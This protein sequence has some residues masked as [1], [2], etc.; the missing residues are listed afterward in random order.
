M[1]Y[2]RPRAKKKESTWVFKSD[3]SSKK[4][5]KG[6]FAARFTCNNAVYTGI[7]YEFALVQFSIGYLSDSGSVSAYANRWKKEAY[8]TITF[9]EEPTGDLLTWLQANA[10]PQ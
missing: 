5:S 2:N 3:I 10:T 1:I 8:R 4:V 7:K 9:E 6:S